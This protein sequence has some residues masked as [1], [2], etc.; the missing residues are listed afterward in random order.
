MKIK[1]ESGRSMVE[2][3]GVLAIIGVLSI[4][5]IAGYTT[6]MNRYRANEVID[7]A[8]KYAVIAYT[9]KQTYATLHPED[10]SFTKFKTPTFT[11]TGLSSDNTINSATFAEAKV[12][13]N[14][15]SIEI[16]FTDAKNVCLAAAS[17][18]GYGTTPEK[19]TEGT[20]ETDEQYKDRLER[21]G[22]ENCDAGKIN[23]VVKQS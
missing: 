8:T 2:M 19:L 23:L 10:T 21:T 18:L 20:A 14:A 13:D 22:Y 1:N 7:Y 4:G 6:A 17:A 12:H 3:L 16:T 5:G 15:T 11:D 9:A